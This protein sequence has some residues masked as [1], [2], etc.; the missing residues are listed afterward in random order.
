MSLHLRLFNKEQNKKKPFRIDDDY[1]EREKKLE[2]EN[3]T[4]KYAILWVRRIRRTYKKNHIVFFRSRLTYLEENIKS[5]TQ[6]LNKTEKELDGIREQVTK[7]T[8][9]SAKHI[10]A[11][12]KFSSIQMEKICNE[13]QVLHQLLTKLQTEECAKSVVK[14]SVWIRTQTY[15]KHVIYRD[16]NNCFNVIEFRPENT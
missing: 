7:A 13:M 9:E 15:T 10:N 1:D 16:I 5:E 12:K 6:N 2:I 14:I 11:Y 3:Q 8:F 4:I